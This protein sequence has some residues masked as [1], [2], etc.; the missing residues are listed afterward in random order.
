M[1]TIKRELWI[2]S[3]IDGEVYGYFA[4]KKAAYETIVSLFEDYV[5]EYAS[6]E[7]FE[8]DEERQMLTDTFLRSDITRQFGNNIYW[9][10][11]D[12]VYGEFM[13]EPIEVFE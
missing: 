12:Y 10:K 3:S 6:E 5:K 9:A 13:L 7:L 11:S 2:V 4:N 1:K 8:I